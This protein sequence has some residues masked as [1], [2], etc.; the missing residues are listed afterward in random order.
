MAAWIVVGVVGGMMCGVV[1]GVWLTERAR[2]HTEVP[3][4]TGGEGSGLMEELV[5]RLM[6]ATLPARGEGAG[7]RE[8]EVG[9]HGGEYEPP[10]DAWDGAT[11]WTDGLVAEVERPLVA[12]LAPGQGIP[13]GGQQQ[14]DV[15]D[16]WREMGQG[17]FDEW[18]RET[19]VPEAADRMSWVEPIDLGDGQGVIE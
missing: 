1:V 16:R 7:E 14:G 4:A 13:L 2:P 9:G 6:D 8:G 12:R 18:A 10:P 17:A 11:D 3:V 5:R 15:V 19:Y